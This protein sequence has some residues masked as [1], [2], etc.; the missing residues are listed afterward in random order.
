MRTECHPLPVESQLLT[1]VRASN[2][3]LSAPTSRVANFRTDWTALPKRWTL[4][5]ILLLSDGQGAVEVEVEQE[6]A[7]EYQSAWRAGGVAFALASRRTEYFVQSVR[8]PS[9]GS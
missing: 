6:A 9:T 7:I 4:P 2:D 3:S 1:L 8:P 5:L